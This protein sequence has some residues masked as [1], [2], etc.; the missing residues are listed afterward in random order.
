MEIIARLNITELSRSTGWLYIFRNRHDIVYRQIS[1][2]LNLIMMMTL[3]Q[4]NVLPSLLRN[5]ALEN[6][7][8]ADEFELSYKLKPD[9]SFV[10]KN[11]TCHSG[12]KN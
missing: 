4:P 8:N 7:Y 2:E 1:N 10:F 11:E 3:L 9:K 6:V 5:H 12:K